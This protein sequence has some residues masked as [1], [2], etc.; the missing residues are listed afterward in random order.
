MPRRAQRVSL[1]KRSDGC[2][3]GG[4]DV[5]GVRL[6]VFLT[7]DLQGLTEGLALSG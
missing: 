7:F 6:A 4:V 5:R 3:E 1:E 2:R